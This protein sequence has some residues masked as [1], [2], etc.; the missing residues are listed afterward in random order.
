M[1]PLSAC[2][3][4]VATSHPSVPTFLQSKPIQISSCSSGSAL[5]RPSDFPLSQLHSIP[6]CIKALGS[7][8]TEQF[9][10]FM[11]FLLTWKGQLGEL[12]FKQIQLS[13]WWFSNLY[14]L[15]SPDLHQKWKNNSRV[16]LPGDSVGL[17]FVLFLIKP[18]TFVGD[19]NVLGYYTEIIYFSWALVGLLP[20]RTAQKRIVLC[21]KR[22]IFYVCKRHCISYVISCSE[23]HCECKWKYTAKDCVG[24]YNLLQSSHKLHRRIYCKRE[25]S[26]KGRIKY[27][28]SS[29]ESNANV[30]LHFIFV[31]PSPPFH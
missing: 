17:V 14:C 10:G 31:C 6:G 20:G 25:N 29:L 19:R 16:W 2:S 5:G 12:L 27:L 21:K 1:P 11:C 4:A 26:M 24:R 28:Q 9:F 3:L 23:V 15:V 30:R 7:L 8:N 18:R 22:N 13:E